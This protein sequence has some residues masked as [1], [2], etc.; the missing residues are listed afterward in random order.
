MLA[1]SCEANFRPMADNGLGLFLILELRRIIF[2]LVKGC[3][4]HSGKRKKVML[5]CGNV[6]RQRMNSRHARALTELARAFAGIES[7]EVTMTS[8]DKLRNARRTHRI[9]A[10]SEQPGRSQNRRHGYG[11]RSAKKVS[12]EEPSPLKSFTQQLP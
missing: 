1:G 3:V 11:D 4:D 5:K 8:V 9:L 6:R 7:E 2:N 10:R 12:A